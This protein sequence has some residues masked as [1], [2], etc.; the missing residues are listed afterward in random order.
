MK[1]FLLYSLN[2]YRIRDCRTIICFTT[3]TLLLT[4]HVKIINIKER[5][6][7][8]LH[9][10]KSTEISDETL[11]VVLNIFSRARKRN[12]WQLKLHSSTTRACA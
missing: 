8:V 9:M 12:L 11:N 5:I 6:L 10:C 7:T 3:N 1:N 2:K 4:Q